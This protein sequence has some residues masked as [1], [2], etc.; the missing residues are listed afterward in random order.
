MNSTGSAVVMCD[1]NDGRSF[2]CSSSTHRSGPCG[3]VGSTDRVWLTLHLCA[4]QVTDLISHACQT[5]SSNLVVDT[6][7]V[8]VVVDA[9]RGYR[10]VNITFVLV[11]VVRRL[12]SVD[13]ALTPGDS[14]RRSMCFDAG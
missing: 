5:G 4:R 1:H 12:P 9:T 11:L 14:D 6:V 13:T 10:W 8:V 7:V 3:T 2:V